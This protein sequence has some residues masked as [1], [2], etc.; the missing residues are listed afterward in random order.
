MASGIL[1]LSGPPAWAMSARP[2]PEPP[3]RGASSRMICPA[4]KRAV[5]NA[6]ERY[7]EGL[8]VAPAPQDHDA[9]FQAV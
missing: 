1:S 8:V 7:E 2:P 5:R 4:L 6:H 9:A 3:T